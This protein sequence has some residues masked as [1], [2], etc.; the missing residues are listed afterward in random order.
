M[1]A[2]APD[3]EKLAD[4]AEGFSPSNLPTWKAMPVKRAHSALES[5]WM[6]FLRP[7]EKNTSR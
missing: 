5:Q 2:A 4:L 3:K 1:N 7:S 6:R